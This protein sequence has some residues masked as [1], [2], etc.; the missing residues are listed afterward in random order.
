MVAAFSNFQSAYLELLLRY[1]RA[2]V[3]PHPAVATL[4][5]AP[6]S[7]IEVERIATYQKSLFF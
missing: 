3:F 7:A 1:P 5:F 4:P 6:P 2:A